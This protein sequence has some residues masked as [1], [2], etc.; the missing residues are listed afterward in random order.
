L[1]ILNEKERRK[2]PI[3]LCCLSF[4]PKGSFYLLCKRMILQFVILKPV[5]T[6]IALILNFFNLYD[7]GSF[8]PKRGYLYLTIVDNVSIG[9]SLYYLILFYIAVEEELE[10]YKPI[11]KFLAIKAVVFFTFWQGV[12]IAIL[13]YFGWI[14]SLGEW[15]PENTATALQD[16]IICIEMFIIAVAHHWIF[17]FKNFRD[18]TK[19]SF[20]KHVCHNI[21][22]LLRNF[23]DVLIPTDVVKDTAHTFDPNPGIKIGY[24]KITKLISREGSINGSGSGNLSNTGENAKLLGSTL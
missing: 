18:P 11:P 21:K 1:D 2:H 22:P 14:K 23:C 9:F 6:G 10:Q 17:P 5:I 20:F 3:P 8:S 4:D 19:S 16:F 15:Q 24:T 12:L 7:D 13:S